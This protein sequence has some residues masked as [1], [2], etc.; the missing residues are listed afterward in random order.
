MF[1]HQKYLFHHVMKCG[2]T[3]LRHI[4][5]NILGHSNVL[6]AVDR[7][8]SLSPASFSH[9]TLIG[10]HFPHLFGSY[11]YAD[12]Y[13]ISMLRHPIDRVL[14]HYF[15][16][17]NNIRATNISIKKTQSLSLS[18]FIHSEDP[19]IISYLSDFQTKT[20]AYLD[21]SVCNLTKDELL[22]KAQEHLSRF[23][24]VGLYEE[25]SDSV[26]F[27]CLRFGFPPVPDIPRENV[28]KDRK[29]NHDLSQDLLKKLTKRNEVDLEFYETAKNLFFRQKRSLLLRV[30]DLNRN[31]G[32]ANHTTSS[33]DI[34][35][36]K[37]HDYPANHEQKVLNAWGDFD[38]RLVEISLSGSC[39]GSNTVSTGEDVVLRMFAESIRHVGNITAGF[40]IKDSAGE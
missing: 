15:F 21:P 27:C 5:E 33:P 35:E 10:G 38:V 22:K 32:L 26:D 4:F 37:D 29:F 28:T 17:K 40:M 16:Y 23:D 25:L 6:W 13:Y 39:S 12:R 2:G 9:P 24:F 7:E 31:T 19:D 3:S 18:E 14:S 11:F 1:V 36:G 8:L 34:I 30:I 20:F